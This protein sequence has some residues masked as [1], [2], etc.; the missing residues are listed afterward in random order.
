MDKYH[1]L[2]AHSLIIRRCHI[3]AHEY[4]TSLFSLAPNTFQSTHPIFVPFHDRT[5][6]AL[7]IFI[8]LQVIGN[9]L[10]FRIALKLKCCDLHQ[11]N[12]NLQFISWTPRIHHGCARR[13]YC[14]HFSLDLLASIWDLD[15]LSWNQ[16]EWAFYLW[17]VI[18]CLYRFNV[19][20]TLW[21]V[22]CWGVI[23]HCLGVCDKAGFYCGVYDL[24]YGIRLHPYSQLFENNDQ[25]NGRVR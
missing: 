21:Q 8:R 22:S 10:I 17:S 12:Q 18:L 9:P 16:D 20:Q 7:D 24:N 1:F 11:V 13:L 19:P 23:F 4:R 2:P 14:N 5:I 25:I 15:R 3:L 6:F